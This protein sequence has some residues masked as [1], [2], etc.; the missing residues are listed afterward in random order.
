MLYRIRDALLGQTVNRKKETRFVY[1]HIPK[2]AGSAVKASIVG[3]R[4]KRRFISKPHPIAFEDLSPR[5]R[6]METFVTIRQPVP[7]YLSM[8]NFKMHSD[9]GKGYDTL[10]ESRLEN[11]LDDVVFARNGLDGVMK[12]NRPVEHKQHIVRMLKPYFESGAHERIGFLTL[13]FLFYTSRRWREALVATDPVAAVTQNR[14]SLI[15]IRH[16]LRQEALS[17]DFA[18]MVGAVDPGLN[19]DQRVNAMS[20]NPYLSALDADV[21]TRIEHRDR[22]I[23]SEFY[24]WNMA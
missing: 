5:E 6:G 19:L 14:D 22:F 15:E 11:F 13:N 24:G 9:G 8:Y 1:L 18:R 17:D 23:L 2:T 3:S 21:I 7:W 4:A 20:T 10:A 16:V 12:W